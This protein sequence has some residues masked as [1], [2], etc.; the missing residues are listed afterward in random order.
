MLNKI[1]KKVSF[2]KDLSDNEIKR[3]GKIAITKKYPA[4]SV[5]FNKNDIGKQFFIVKKG[6]VKIY[7]SVG[8]K[9]KTIALIDKNSFFGEM[10]LIGCKNRSASAV[11]A[12]DTELF[13]ISKKEFEDYIYKNPSFAL[14]LLSTLA[15]RLN[16][17]DQEIE[18]M[19]FHNM[20]GRLSYVILDISKSNGYALNLKIDQNEIADYL[21]TTR[22]PVCRAINTLK[23]SGIIGYSREKLVIRDMNRLKSISRRK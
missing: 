10:S 8:N 23:R 14:N 16:K 4:N 20:L 13:V 7:T 21:G 2:L 22:V 12:E 15:E 19:L 5:I 9:K 17:A 3:I 6:R 1:L 11:T 18:A